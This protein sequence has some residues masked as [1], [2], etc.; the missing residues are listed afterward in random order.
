[1]K[2][3]RSRRPHAP[4]PPGAHRHRLELAILP[5]PTDTTCGPTCLHAVYRFHGD[6][7][8][9]QQV[10]DEVPSLA[11]GG[12]LAVN[13]GLHALGRG[14]DAL[15]HSNNLLVFDPTWADPSGA[16]DPEL[17]LAKLALRH[18]A[19]DDVKLRVAIEAYSRFVELGGRVHLDEFSP[20]LFLG[21]LRQQRPIL[22]G[23][24]ST[25]L[26]RSARERY[27]GD[28]AVY[29]DVAGAPQGHFVVLAGYDEQTAR[30][31]VADPYLPNPL[32]A[33]HHYS[34]SV[35]RALNAILL[36]VLTYDA[37]LLVIT[38]RRPGA[39]A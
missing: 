10:I 5:Q 32:G 33:Q 11:E 7:L 1:M 9:L 31:L 13:L 2:R 26:Y 30:V 35:D 6:V 23:L 14:Y 12:T 16:C 21:H 29:D 15:L 22:A 36:G 20:Q 34:V 24:S 37:N 18:E 8:P 4:R 39:A 3:P 27:E 25:W 17:L 19:T 38:P 28:R